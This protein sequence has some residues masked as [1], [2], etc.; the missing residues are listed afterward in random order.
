MPRVQKVADSWRALLD[1]KL[2]EGRALWSAVLQSPMEDQ[3]T[4]SEPDLPHEPTISSAGVP[5]AD[6]VAAGSPL[7]TAIVPALLTLAFVHGVLGAAPDA[8]R[9]RLRLRPFAT[10]TW[11]AWSVNELRVG[12]ARV[13]VALRRAGGGISVA[14]EQTA[15]AF[16]LRLVLE[17]ILPESRVDGMAVD[18]R[19]ATLDVRRHGPGLIVPVQLMLDDRRVVTLTRVSD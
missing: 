15:G 12:D 19:S 17:L 1:G 7:A 10:R 18:G 3:N 14:V 6:V 4:L 13:A 11:N 8:A 2:E 16:P 5:G 9:Q